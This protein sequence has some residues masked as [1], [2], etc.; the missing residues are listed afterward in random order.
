MVEAIW[1]RRRLLIIAPSAYPL[2]GV[3]EWLDYLLGGLDVVGWDCTL[4]LTSG[5]LHNLRAYE[6]LHPWRRII[7]V[8]NRSG[9]GEGRRRAVLRLL[10]ENPAEI[11]LNVNIASTFAAVRYLRTRD[12]FSAKLVVAIHALEEC[13]FSD[14]RDNSDIVD[15]VVTPNRL[16]TRL[17]GEA[18]GRTDRVFYAPCGVEIRNSARSFRMKERFRGAMRILFCGRVEQPQKRVLDLVQLAMQMQALRIDCT[19]V[20]AGNGPAMLELRSAV[21][22]AGLQGEFEFLGTVARCDLESVYDSC[23]ALV[24]TSAWETG[25]IVAW[26]AMARGVPVVTSRFVG[27]GLEA[28]LIDGENCLL[29]PIS[30]MR[31]AAARLLSLRDNLLRRRVIS[32]GFSLVRHR[33]SRERSIAEWRSAL[34]SLVAMPSVGAP[35]SRKFSVG[36]RA[37]GFGRLDKWFGVRMAESLRVALG[38]SHTH[39]DAGGEWPHSNAPW[40]DQNNFLG[41]ASLKDG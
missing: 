17:A 5:A 32:G 22:S 18:L 13:Y 40:S 10:R 19:V 39:S 12:R 7:G 16:A 21:T 6:R 15:G 31:A 27:S 23:D 3:A 14:I 33:Y 37:A 30:D 36:K 24:V 41:A 8:S 11:I 20:V 2:G 4:A 9:T 25:P 34:D 38:L 35:V 1:P 28:A 26:E 29:F